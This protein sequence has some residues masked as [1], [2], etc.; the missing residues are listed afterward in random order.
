MS[1]GRGVLLGQAAPAA[2]ADTD[3]SGCL[4]SFDAPQIGLADGTAVSTWADQSGNARDMTRAGSN[5]PTYKTAIQN[6]LAIVRFAAAS[7]QSMLRSSDSMGLT[8][9]DVPFSV[10]AVAKPTGT[11]G[12]QTIFGL[13]RAASNT[14][15][16][17]LR[18]NGANRQSVRRDDANSSKSISASGATAAWHV[19]VFSF[20]GTAGTLRVDGALVGSAGTDLDVGTITLDRFSVGALEGSSQSGPFDGDIGHVAVWSHAFDDSEVERVGHAYA[21]R[22]AIAGTW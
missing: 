6:G 8:G 11:T 16:H 10:A 19:W 7:F 5:R 17:A 20:T 22:W 18:L 12:I 9:S 15:F 14:P 13:G 2:F 1:G 4:A 21:V 3:I